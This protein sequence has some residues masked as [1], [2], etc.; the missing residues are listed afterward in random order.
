MAGQAPIHLTRLHPQREV[1]ARVSAGGTG[2]LTLANVAGKPTIAQLYGASGTL[3]PIDYV[4]E[5]G[6]DADKWEI[7]QGS[8][9]LA[10][11]QLTRTTPLATWDGSTLDVTTP[12]AIDFATTRCFVRLTALPLPVGAGGTGGSTAIA[13]LDALSKQGTSI[14]SAAT[15]DLSAVT[16]D[17]VDIT[18][19]TTIT[20]LG[21]ATAGVRRSLRFTGALTLTH[22]GTSLILPGSANL[23]TVAGDIVHLRSLGSG[24]WLCT[25]VQ[26]A[27]AIKAADD[28]AKQGASIAS[29]STVDLSAATGDL[30]DVTGTT[31]ITAFGTVAAA[32]RRTVRFT[33]ALTLTYNATSL[34]LPG[35]ADIVTAAGDV[36]ELRSLGSGN[37]LCTSYRRASGRPVSTVIPY[38]AI[39]SSLTADGTDAAADACKLLV[40]NASS[41]ITRTLP[42]SL[43]VG[44][45]IEYLNLSDYPVKISAG[46]D[47]INSAGF[48][49]ILLLKGCRARLIYASGSDPKWR[50]AEVG[51]TALAFSASNDIAT[52]TSTTLADVTGMAFRCVAAESFW[53]DFDVVFTAAA[54]TTGIKLG[55]TLSAVTGL[56]Y[57]VD[58]PVAA[59]G[60]SA[61]YFGTGVS[62][63]DAVTA[64]GVESTTPDQYIARVSGVAIAS[65]DGALLQLQAATEVGSSA[66]VIKQR[67]RGRCTWHPTS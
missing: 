8:L 1:I 5:Q 62:S 12:A 6:R 22:N 13:A 20:A 46:T 55:V 66:I 60:V 16:G 40:C 48:D 51:S 57:N 7:G 30:V 59:D 34:I 61:R 4:V 23:V 15:V 35:L 67:T 39:P 29:A 47:G 10:T 45:W 49:Q 21:T 56:R 33:G 52:L 54:T 27:T 17:L 42:A 26:R 58:A 64:T 65:S 2:V 3:S 41:V 25:G 50:C 11:L 38:V 36:A 24:N 9:N 43:N 37:W 28:L 63:G 53:F 14:A 44:E 32:A 18:G 31:T 19:T